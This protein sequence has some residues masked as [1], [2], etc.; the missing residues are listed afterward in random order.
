MADGISIKIDGDKELIESLRRLEGKGFRNIIQ[1]SLRSGARQFNRDL[2]SSAPVSRTGSKAN[3][4]SPG[5]LRKS[6]RVKKTRDRFNPK[7]ARYIVSYDPK[8]AF[9]ARFV[10]RGTK[11][12]YGSRK[13]GRK[14]SGEV[15]PNPFVNRVFN[16]KKNKVGS[17]I[18]NEIER[19]ANG[20]IRLKK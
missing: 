5:T 17:D 10:I 1:G 2:K 7:T 8:R 13:R 11:P 15:E 4:Y 9:Y 20:L 16:R 14:F 19:G 18:V 6:I 12:R 3:N